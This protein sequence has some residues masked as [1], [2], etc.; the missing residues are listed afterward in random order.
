DTDPEP[1]RTMSTTLAAVVRAPGEPVRV[2][3][4]TLPDVGPGQVRVRMAAAGACHS[5]LSL[6]SGKL[7]HP[8]P[9]AL[10]HEG[11]GSDV[12]VGEGVTGMAVGDQ[13]LLHLNPPCRA[14]WHCAHGEPYLRANAPDASRRVWGTLADG[15]E[16]HP[17]LGVA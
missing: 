13:V 11:T 17:C 5:A 1:R 10:G 9:A 12:G 7:A 3:E 6:A 8:L 15:T 4:V 16:L 2:E 14:C